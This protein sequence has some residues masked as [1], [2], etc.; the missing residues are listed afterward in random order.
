[1]PE[2]HIIDE[3]YIKKQQLSNKY[4]PAK[5]KDEKQGIYKEYGDNT[6]KKII[7]N[8][9]IKTKYFI[10][11]FYPHLE[12]KY[13]DDNFNIKINTDIPDYVQTFSHNSNDVNKKTM[14][15]SSIFRITDNDEISTNHFN[16]SQN[17]FGVIFDISNTDI[18]DYYYADAQSGESNK[19]QQ[20]DDTK[21]YKNENV[22]KQKVKYVLPDADDIEPNFQK[23]YF[24][25]KQTDKAKK[26]LIKFALEQNSRFY[27]RDEKLLTNELIAS[28][29]GKFMFHSDPNKKDYY[30]ELLLKGSEKSTNIKTKSIIVSSD[31]IDNNN[32]INYLDDIKQICNFQQ[33]KHLPFV[34]IFDEEKINYETD[35]ITDRRKIYPL[36]LTEFIGRRF[37]ILSNKYNAMQQQGQQMSQPECLEMIYLS[38]LFANIQNWEQQQINFIISKK[39]E[40]LNIKIEELKDILNK[41]YKNDEAK[42]IHDLLNDENFLIKNLPIEECKERIRK[43]LFSEKKHKKQLIDTKNFNESMI[44]TKY[45]EY[46]KRN[47]QNKKPIINMRK[48][49]KKNCKNI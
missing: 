11:S 22:Y 17:Y 7:N 2:D 45:N 10:A 26:D 15:S 3:I 33:K 31:F 35:K 42:L 19:Y 6:R 9:L 18:I 48:L 14:I 36:K 16:N 23:R 39:A 40:K 5:K 46:K 21:R 28:P 12:N 13:Y 4:K 24:I 38:N 1:M 34:Y 30:N 27:I 8:G 32:G 44:N 37:S 41:K 25:T 47:K 43:T 29:V 20:V 49:N